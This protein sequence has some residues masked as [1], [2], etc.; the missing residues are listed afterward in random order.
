MYAF[1]A[2]LTVSRSAAFRESLEMSGSIKN[3]LDEVTD[4]HSETEDE[5]NLE[6]TSVSVH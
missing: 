1:D 6:A 5:F 4:Y 2:T 3:H